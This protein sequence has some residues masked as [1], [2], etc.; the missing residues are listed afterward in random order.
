M[1]FKEFVDLMVNKI[2]ETFP[3]EVEVIINEVE[4]LYEIIVLNLQSNIGQTFYANAFYDIYNETNNLDKA[5]NSIIELVGK[6]VN[7]APEIKGQSAEKW[8]SDFSKV[9]DMVYYVLLDEQVLPDEILHEKYLDMMK[10]YYIFYKGTGIFIDN[11]I[12]VQRKYLEMWNI[13]EEELKAVAERN[14]Q[15]QPVEIKPLMD[16]LKEHASEEYE[17]VKDMIDASSSDLFIMRNTELEYGAS[18]MG[19]KEVIRQFAKEKGA[20]VFIIPS[21]VY[22]VI[23]VA[24]KWSG[25]EYEDMA[26][27]FEDMLYNINHN[28]LSQ[29]NVLSDSLYIYRRETD[30]IEII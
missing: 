13:T 20:D 28:V 12:N 15:K 18:A 17:K 5:I 24:N 19:N 25:E 30:N 29:E 8:L 4:D 3:T 7:N 1:E 10:Q 2:K 6:L 11:Y 26:L 23:L 22:E 16:V 9:Q 27:N 21:S 14:M